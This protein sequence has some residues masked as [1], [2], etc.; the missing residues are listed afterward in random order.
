[1]S[2]KTY[3][4]HHVLE[5]VKLQEAVDNTIIAEIHRVPV[6]ALRRPGHD[7]P[8]ANMTSHPP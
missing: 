1:M 7:G 4:E 6:G 2:R 5:G 8:M 3:L